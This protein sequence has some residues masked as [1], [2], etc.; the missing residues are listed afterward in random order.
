MRTLCILLLLAASHAAGA[1]GCSQCRDNLASTPHQTQA[2]YR[3]A[4]LLLMST[5]G[6]LFA[7]SVLLIRRYR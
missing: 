5:G 2:A 4:I 1:Q 3:H 7:A 6:G